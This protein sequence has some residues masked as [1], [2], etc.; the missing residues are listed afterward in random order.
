MAQRE[1]LCVL[2]DH[3]YTILAEFVQKVKANKTCLFHCLQ[4]G[5]LVPRISE[6]TELLLSAG[7]WVAV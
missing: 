2:H 6:F 7:L 4:F 5:M 1:E 3:L